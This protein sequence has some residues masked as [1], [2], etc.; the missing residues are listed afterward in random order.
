MQEEQVSTLQ[1]LAM[2]SSQQPE[3]ALISLTLGVWEQR[4][5]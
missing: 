2:L 3:D 1:A 5:K 4:I